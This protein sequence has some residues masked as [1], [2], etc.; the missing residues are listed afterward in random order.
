MSA[1][2]TPYLPEALDECAIVNC[3]CTAMNYFVALSCGD[4]IGSEQGCRI[5]R[6]GESI[7]ALRMNAKSCTDEPS[8][9]GPYAQGVEA[10]NAAGA[11]GRVTV[12]EEGCLY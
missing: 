6:E 4:E 12:S 7:A 8:D 9:S 1:V 3:V 2:A 11:S 5:Y 10:T